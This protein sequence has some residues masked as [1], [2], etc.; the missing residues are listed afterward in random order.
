MGGGVAQPLHHLLAAFR[1][2]RRRPIR[3]RRL[4]L[5]VGVDVAELAAKA[6]VEAGVAAGKVLLGV[7]ADSLFRTQLHRLRDALAAAIRSED[8]RSS[9]WHSYPSSWELAVLAPVFL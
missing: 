3:S 9:A 2:V 4:R 7:A 8:P 6:N 1:P 5:G